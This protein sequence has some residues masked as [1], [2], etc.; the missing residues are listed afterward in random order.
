ML[1][2][3][4]FLLSSRDLIAGS[5]KNLK[6]INTIN[7]FLDTVVKPRYDLEYILLRQNF[8]FFLAMTKKH[9]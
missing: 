4:A 3:A 7:Y 5:N 9:K 6:I 2:D 1:R 8:Q